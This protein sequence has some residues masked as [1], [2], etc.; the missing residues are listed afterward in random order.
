MSIAKLIP[1]LNT[2]TYAEKLRVMQVLLGLV[3]KDIYQGNT[4]T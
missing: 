4:F 2:L 1:I 3:Q